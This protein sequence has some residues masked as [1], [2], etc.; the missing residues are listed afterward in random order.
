MEFGHIGDHR[1]FQE[2]AIGMLNRCI[3]KEQHNII[4]ILN[5]MD[6]LR[7]SDIRTL[8]GT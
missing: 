4:D 3:K 8:L 2:W 7:F 6:I 1:L 5:D